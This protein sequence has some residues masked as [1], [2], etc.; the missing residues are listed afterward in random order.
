MS[1][2]HF[3]G[4]GPGAPDL[5]TIRAKQQIETADVIVYTGSLI[6]PQVLNVRKNEAK[7]FDSSSMTLKEIVKVMKDAVKSGLEVVRLHT[8]DP[9]VYSTVREQMDELESEGIPFDVTPGVSAFQ[10]AAASLNA[11]LTMPGISQSLTITRIGGRTPVPAAQSLASYAAHRATLALYLSAARA[12]AV[13]VQLIAGGYPETTPV[14]V[15]YKASWPEER[16][17]TATLH[18]LPDVM[19]QEGIDRTAVILVGEVL[20][21]AARPDTGQAGHTDVPGQREAL[22]S[23]LYD[24]SFT[25]GY[26]DSAIHHFALFACTR[27]GVEQM[28]RAAAALQQKDPAAR[29]RE[30]VKVRGVP[31]Y[32]EKNI[33]DLTKEVF[34]SADLIVYFA[35]SGIAVRS[36]APFVH[37]KAQDPAV[38]VVDEK[39]KYCIPILSGHL[40]H[41]NEYASF[42]SGVL[43]GEAVITTAT[44]LEQRFS[45]DQFAQAN[46]LAIE[47]LSEARNIS[48]AIL[49]GE[50]ITCY[51]DPDIQA[52]DAMPSQIVQAAERSRAA[53]I[54]SAFKDRRDPEHCLHLIPANIVAGIGC[55]RGVRSSDVEDAIYAALAKGRVN[56]RSLAGTA[57]IELKREERGI[58]EAAKSLHVGTRFFSAEQLNRAPG[59]FT[60]SDFVFR[61]TGTDSVAERSAVLG[62]RGGRLV[63]PRMVSKDVTVALAA[64]QLKIHWQG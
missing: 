56:G 54:I 60:H 50:Q 32:L 12:D 40:G 55:R 26:R 52:E 3:V 15:I 28:H 39:G 13:R 7:L 25:T 9:S 24:G 31:G 17:I 6:N 62:S 51:M 48:A 38:V 19:R 23:S 46:Q 34:P 11:E 22:R 16:V 41:A 5:L 58:L 63:L 30:I 29:I 47:D 8:G 59:V 2:V 35:A 49:R 37:S 18:D 44:D 20:R 14:A 33:T 36:I 64:A 27:Q 45:V 4:A 43:G 57:S 61:T 21:S 53:V 10:A 42:L 1:K